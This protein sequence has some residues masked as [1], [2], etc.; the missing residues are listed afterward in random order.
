Y[1]HWFVDFE[2]PND[3]GKP[4][5]SSGGKMLY[6][7][8][9]E[10]EIPVG[11]EDGVLGDLVDTINGY[12]FKSKDFADNG[13][14]AIIKIKNV[15]PPNIDIT[16]TH[17][18]KGNLTFELDRFIVSKGDILITMTGSGVNQMNSAVGQVGKYYESKNS[19]LNQ[20]VCKLEPEYKN[21]K[22]YVFQFISDKTTHIE[23]LNGSTGS[24]NQ[25]NISPTQIKTLILII[26]NKSILHKYQ[27]AMNVFNAAKRVNNQQSLEKIKDLVLAKMSKL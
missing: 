13:D 12:A 26:P 25:A 7:E 6:N 5:K 8:V 18:L 14:M 10:K 19:L 3:D 24:A 9:L 21:I 2:F 20:R 17:Y 11:W 27:Q 4:Y 1:K 16:D 22:E 23:L 15:V